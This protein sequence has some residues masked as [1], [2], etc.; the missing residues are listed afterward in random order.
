MAFTIYQIFLAVLMLI[1]GSLNTL[2]TKWADR[3]NAFFCDKVTNGTFQHPFLQATGMFLG[4]FLCLLLFKFLWFSTLKYRTVQLKTVEGGVPPLMLSIVSP[5]VEGDQTFNPLI[6]WVASICDMLSTCLSYIGLNYTTASSFQM[7]R[8]SVMIFTALLSIIFLK[9]KLTLY[10]WIGLLTV[11]AG[12]TVVGVSDILFDKS[13]I[14]L[15][16]KIAG[17]LLILVAQIFTASQVVY[18]E[19]FISKYNIPPLQAVG[20]EGI[21]GFGTLGLLLIPFYFIKIGKSNTGPAH[22]LEDIPEAFCQMKSNGIII[23]ATVG[24]IFSIAFFNFAGIS[25]TK[26]LS[27]TTRMVLDSGRTLVIWMVSLALR[28]QKFYPLQ[29]VGFLLLI[30]GM[31]IYNGVWLHLIRKFIRRQPVDDET[32]TMTEDHKIAI[33]DD[34]VQLRW[35]RVETSEIEQTIIKSSEQVSDCVVIKHTENEKH[36]HLIAYVQQPSSIV[37]KDLS[38]IRSYC[39]LHLPRHMVPSLFII[40]DRLPLNSTGKLDRRCLPKPDFSQ[41]GSLDHHV[42]PQHR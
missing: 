12:L 36:E 13:D 35:Q 37:D 16:Y 22:R 31:G 27:S 15:V 29:I 32:I 8:G 10:N 38:Q 20:W 14:K 24:N 28:W 40:L 34:V 19:R 11:V 39:Q 2:S 7:L 1:T 18:E 9:K 30:I 25:I 4:E 21:F 6:F 23:V 5:L 26:E 17:D 42:E 3:Q 33:A 41:T